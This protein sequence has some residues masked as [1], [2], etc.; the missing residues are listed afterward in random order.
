MYTLW[1]FI[2]QSSP[3]MWRLSQ[4]GPQPVFWFPSCLPAANPSAPMK[5]LICPPRMWPWDLQGAAQGH[6]CHL[7]YYHLLLNSPVSL[8]CVF[9]F[10][11]SFPWNDGK[12]RRGGC[13][14]LPRF[15]LRFPAPR[16]HKVFI[17]LP[18]I[19]AWLSRVAILH[20]MPHPYTRLVAHSCVHFPE[21][22][23]WGVD[24]WV[25]ANAHLQLTQIL[26]NGSLHSVATDTPNCSDETPLLVFLPP[27]LLSVFFFF[28]PFWCLC[29]DRSLG[30]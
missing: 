30:F 10:L 18:S 27:L 23:S 7:F 3:G 28:Y 8:A 21:L 29:S 5:V 17:H 26:A 4:L 13:C 2:F 20:L 1:L 11:V 25:W 12:I 14:S 16:R 22:Y 19:D 6:C 15:R 9:S 24:F